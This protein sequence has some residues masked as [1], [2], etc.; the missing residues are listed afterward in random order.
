MTVG[1]FTLS[2][3]G[4]F[5]LILKVLCIIPAAIMGYM[6]LLEYRDLL[7]FYEEPTGSDSSSSEGRE[8]IEVIIE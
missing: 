8:V 4:S 3:I 6:A 5:S 7:E 1:Y 2:M